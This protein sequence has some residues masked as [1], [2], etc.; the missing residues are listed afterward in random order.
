MLTATLWVAFG[1]IAAAFI[2]RG[3]K[4]S[5]FRQAWI[6]GLRTD[7]SEYISKAHQWIELYLTFNSE[8]GQDKKSRMK[9]ELDRLK[10][11]ALHIHSR[12][13]L[14][15]KPDDEAADKLLANLLKLLDPASTGLDNNAYSNWRGLSDS[16]VNEARVLLKEEWETT[17]NPILKLYKKM[18]NKAFKSDS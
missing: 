17:K 9:P 11:D 1:V 12:I 13:S 6:D 18:P 3:V 8:T 4:I 15:F 16:V 5:E 7:I 2:A 14:R 10:Y